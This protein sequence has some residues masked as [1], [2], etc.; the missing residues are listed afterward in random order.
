MKNGKSFIALFV[1]IAVLLSSLPLVFF[2]AVADDNVSNLVEAVVFDETYAANQR[3]ANGTPNWRFFTSNSASSD[4]RTNFLESENAF[5]FLGITNVGN[6]YGNRAILL[7]NSFSK[8]AIEAGKRYKVVFDL[9]LKGENLSTRTVDIRFGSDVWSPDSSYTHP[10]PAT[11]MELIDEKADGSFTCYTLGLIVTAPSSKNLLLSVYGNGANAAARVKNAM[12]YKTFFYKCVDEGDNDVGTLEA[13]PGEDLADIIPGSSVDK[14]GFFENPKSKTVP[15]DPNK[16][17]VIGYEADKSFVS[18]IGFDSSYGVGEETRYFVANSGTNVNIMKLDGDSVTVDANTKTATD[19]FRYRSCVLANDYLNSGL[20]AGTNYIVSFDLLVSSSIDVSIYSVELRSGRYASNGLTGDK[21]NAVVFDGQDL[22]KYTVSLKKTDTGRIYSISL[23]YTL[24]AEANWGSATERNILMSV[25]GGDRKCTLDNVEIA[26][27]SDIILNNTDLGKLSGRIGYPITM[28]DEPS[29]KEHIFLGWYKEPTFDTLF[30]ST[31]FAD[32]DI[33]IYA[34]FEKVDITA[35]MD[36]ESAPV[37][38]ANLHNFTYNSSAKNI[39]AT[40]SKADTAYLKF[41]NNGKVIRLSPDNYYPISFRYMTDGYNGSISFGAVNASGDSFDVAKNVLVQTTAAASNSWSK[42]SFV[43]TPE[44]LRENGQRGDYLYFYI[45]YDKAAGGKIY[46]DD[47]VIKQE[48]SVSYVTNGGNDIDK[49]VGVPGEEFTLPTPVKAGSA[50]SGWYYDEQ[51]STSKAGNKINYPTATPEIVL[52]ALWDS[53]RTTVSTDGLENYTDSEIASNPNERQKEVF[54]VSHSKAKSGNASMK[55]CYAPGV[56]TAVDVQ[57][58]S[59]KLKG[60]SGSSSTGITV[61]QYKKDAEGNILRDEN[62][63]SIAQD[64]VMSFYVYAKELNTSVDFIAFTASGSSVRVN[65][66]KTTSA[67]SDGARITPELFPKNEWKKVYYVF[68]ATPKTTEA[69]EI[70]LSVHNNSYSVVTE[71]YIDDIHVEKLADDMG[72]VAFTTAVYSKT[73]VEME[74]NFAVGKVGETIVTPETTRANYKLE[75]WY[76]TY[77]YQ[78]Q[79][80]SEFT[81]GVLN[82]YPQWDIEGEIKVSFENV[83]DYPRD[84]TGTSTSN[85]FTNHGGGE[86]VVNEHSSDGKAAWRVSGSGVNWEKVLALKEADGSPFRLVDSRSYIIFVDIYIEDYSADFGFNFSTASQDNYYAWHGSTTGNITVNA[87]TPR[88]K[89]ITTALTMT[90]SFND[91]GGFNLFLRT[92]SN[93][94]KNVVYFDNVR[95]RSLDP[96]KVT[97]IIN[98]GLVAGNVDVITGSVGETYTLPEDIDVEGYDFLGW[99]SSPAMTNPVDFEDMFLET[100]TV[101][102][103]LVPKVYTNNFEKWSYD[104]ADTN[105]GDKDYEIY[106]K[107]APGNKAENVHGGDY[108]LH[109]KGEDYQRK[110]VIIVQKNATLATGEAYELSF[111]VKMDKYDHTNGA[112]KIAS[113]SSSKYA[114]DLIGDMRAV[115]PIADLTDGE[116]HQVKYQFMASA[117]YLSLQTPGYCSIF[118]DDVTVTHLTTPGISDEPVYT[119]YIPVKKNAAGKIPTLIVDTDETDITDSS[120]ETYEKYQLLLDELDEIENAS[121][122]PSDSPQNEP[123]DNSSQAQPTDD[124]SQN[125]T[126]YDSQEVTSND[127]QDIT[128]DNS[129]EVT[130]D[131]SQDITNDNSQDVT[132]DDPQNATNNDSQEVTTNNSSSSPSYDSTDSWLEEYDEGNGALTRIKKKSTTVSTKR[133]ALTFKDILTCNSYVWYT[134][135][136]YAGVGLVLAAIA[137][138]TIF[139]ILRKKR[140]G[141]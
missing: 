105:G 73:A 42:V 21:A 26:Y 29:K 129:Q 54:S 49:S 107:N 31:V 36:F 110:N 86:V 58:S 104:F 11:D 38:A 74:Y 138:A 103:K 134:V 69:N 44:V 14:H 98:K 3:D 67:N 10:I 27:R 30:S 95:I 65:G 70:Y 40:T 22:L 94:S 115:V 71:L 81:A 118:I 116:W 47:I 102:A 39:Y 62:N 48:T 13:F 2:S 100:K 89:W 46:V 33:N 92:N 61:E 79:L 5:E 7:S 55:Y 124:S 16:E 45:Q 141:K 12:I 75:G 51:F 127:S 23:P 117:Y 93:G 63:K 50:F 34:K 106:D 17:I 24:S 80:S 52:Y 19:T 1:I 53:N 97:V 96:S 109:R 87:D 99:F 132:S 43:A 9:L 123:E 76:S 88:G 139:V 125:V 82:A 140:G 60:N 18:F 41:Y 133:N 66:S 111:W 15:L 35:N 4:G 8:T 85:K 59:F 128:N 130:P 137:A 84:G 20:V 78:K 126:P 57:N 6:S 72:A 77:R 68:K 122:V 119:E 135:V 83:A 120:L 131:D 114:W 91:Y 121:D 136:F 64:Y 37:S 56:N 101:Y 108:S 28:P 25:F 32:D 113:C 112:I 90:T